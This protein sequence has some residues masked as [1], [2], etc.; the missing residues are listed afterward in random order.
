MAD[1]AASVKDFL[2][3][4]FTASV[5]RKEFTEQWYAANNEWR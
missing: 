3:K 2:T 4:P 1:I 5:K